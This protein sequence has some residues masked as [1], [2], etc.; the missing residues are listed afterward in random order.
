MD[1]E[2]L[3]KSYPEKSFSEKFQEKKKNLVGIGVPEDQLN[4]IE[5]SFSKVFD[6]DKVVNNFYK[7]IS[8][9]KNINLDNRSFNKIQSNFSRIVELNN[10][11]ESDLVDFQ[12]KNDVNQ[13]FS[14]FIE[15][16]RNKGYLDNIRYDA[17]GR[18]VVTDEAILDKYIDELNLINKEIEAPNFNLEKLKEAEDVMNQVI[19]NKDKFENAS[20]TAENWIRT[21]QKAVTMSIKDK[22][23]IFNKKANNDHAGKN[24]GWWLAA[25]VIIGIIMVSCVFYFIKELDG[26]ENVSVGSALLRISS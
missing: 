11:L 15:F 19:E 3:L 8:K 21:D 4:N 1:I 20:K 12:N 16:L 23:S 5:S 25:S 18:S 2:N 6:Y 13:L 26:V 22:A 10:H 7:K 17:G 14:G 9:N 24:Y